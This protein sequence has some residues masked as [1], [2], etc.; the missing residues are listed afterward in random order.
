[1]GIDANQDLDSIEYADGQSWGDYFRSMAVDALVQTAS[2]YNE[3]MA[4]GYEIS[5][6]TQQEIDNYS[7]SI[8]TY[9]E[10]NAMTRDQF[11]HAAAT[12]LTGVVT[13]PRTL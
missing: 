1:M 8:D 2:M 6:A 13:D 4:N 7:A 10:N 12:A 9:C 5:D 11:L 3:A